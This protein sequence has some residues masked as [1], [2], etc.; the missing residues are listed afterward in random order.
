MDETYTIKFTV[1][2]IEYERPCKDYADAHKLCEDMVKEG[3]YPKMV[4]TY[5]E[6]WQPESRDRAIAQN[7]N[8]GIHYDELKEEKE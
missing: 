1:A 7:G 6:D 2:G 8:D 4:I 5:T 3:I